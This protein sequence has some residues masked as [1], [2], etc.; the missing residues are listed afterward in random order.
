MMSPRLLLFLMPLLALSGC[1]SLTGISQDEAFERPPQAVELTEVPYHPQEAYQCGPAALAEVLGW[2]GIEVEPEELE[3]SLF[4]PERKGTLQVE[5]ISQ[6]RQ[7]DRVPYQIDGS[8][9]AIMQELEA[10]NPVLVF[11]NLSLRWF[12]IWH[13]AVIVGYDPEAERFILRSGEHKRLET[14]LDRFRRTWDRGD[15]WAMVVTRPDQLPASADANR[16]FRAGADLEQTGRSDSALRVFETGRE[17]WPEHAGFHLG[18][19]NLHFAA[20]E[21]EAAEDAIRL[22]LTEAEGN[23]GVLWNNLAGLLMHRQDWD[24]AIDAAQQAVASGGRFAD[25]FERTLEQTQCRGDQD[26]LDQLAR[27]QEDSE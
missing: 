15:R 16:W 1:A 26:C 9:D 14:K 7:R 24:A 10:G 22:G 21:L 27:Q 12:P 13:Y 3:P 20:G 23:H 17:K 25:N 19:F 18:L 8:F 5:L 6:T 4:I 11:Q 2:S